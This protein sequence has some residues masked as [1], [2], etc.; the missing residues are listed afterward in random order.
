MKEIRS[1]LQ[2]HETSYKYYCPLC[3]N[4]KAAKAAS[5]RLKSFMMAPIPVL[6]KAA[7]GHKSVVAKKSVRIN[8]SHGP[9]H[10]ESTFEEEIET[11]QII[12]EPFGKKIKP[13]PAANLPLSI[14]EN[15][16]GKIKEKEEI[17]T[18]TTTTTSIQIF[19][20]ATQSPIAPAV[21]TISPLELAKKRL[22]AMFI[23]NQANRKRLPIKLEPIPLPMDHYN[24]ID[25]L[26]TI[27]S[28]IIFH[29][30]PF[31]LIK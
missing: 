23:K 22:D 7:S 20:L 30:G 2:G 8:K 29:L 18:T 4:D 12:E 10:A 25:K 9:A 3:R 27:Y 5:K 15:F 21:N 13:N 11:D 28:G 31:F 1:L 17:G 16:L 6:N 19:N 26:M 14:I 24:D